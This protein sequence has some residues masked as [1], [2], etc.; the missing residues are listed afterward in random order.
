MISSRDLGPANS[1][2]WSAA[3]DGERHGK[4]SETTE[5][6]S[7]PATSGRILYF[8]HVADGL[9][10]EAGGGMG[11]EEGARRDLAVHVGAGQNGQRLLADERE[12]EQDR[13]DRDER[14]RLDG[15]LREPLGPPDVTDEGRRPSR[16]VGLDGHDL[17]LTREHAWHRSLSA[18]S[19]AG[20]SP[21]P[22]RSSVRP[23]R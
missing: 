6:F 16:G 20:S 17:C 1:E 10:Q 14:H 19:A 21:R 22:R 7:V 9:P 12:D 13:E 18:S 8:G 23:V 3:Q 15:P 4:T 5:I 11:Q 2:T